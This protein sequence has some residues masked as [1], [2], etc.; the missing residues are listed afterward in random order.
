MCT[1]IIFFRQRD[2]FNI[3]KAYAIYDPK[4]GYCQVHITC[5]RIKEIQ[6]QCFFA[7]LCYRQNTSTS[8]DLVSLIKIPPKSLDRL[9]K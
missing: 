8:S 2:L 4:T 9:I 7:W 1:V 5:T 6:Q 3:L